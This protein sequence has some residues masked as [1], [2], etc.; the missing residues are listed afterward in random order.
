MR[1]NPLLVNELRALFKSGATPS[2]LIRCIVER[3][4]GEPAIDRV[5]RA[6][7]REAFLVPM[8]QIGPEQV[9]QIAQGIGLP[10]L[11]G[12][13]VHRMVATRSEWDK[14]AVQDE[15]QQTCWLDSLAATDEAELIRKTDPKALP[16]LASS[17]EQLSEE[18]KRYITRVFANAQSLSERAT[19]L[20]ALAEQLQQRLLASESMEA[21]NR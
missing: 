13:V 14:P 10:S 16:E 5:V 17:W 12:S 21:H 18:G 19:V 4:P 2:A 7:F 15:T 9:A 20:A 1:T 3:H 6:Y 8:L 11:N